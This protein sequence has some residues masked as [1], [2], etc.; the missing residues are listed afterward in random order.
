MFTCLCSSS[1]V[2]DCAS[3]IL[4]PPMG[5]RPCLLFLLPQQLLI[6]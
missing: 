1:P 6:L 5:A 2:M 3:H 4:L